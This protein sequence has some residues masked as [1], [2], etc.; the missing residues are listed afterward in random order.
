MEEE[1]TGSGGLRPSVEDPRLST[2]IPK[3]GPSAGPP[4]AG[5]PCE[6]GSL[7]LWSAQIQAQKDRE[8]CQP[9]LERQVENTSPRVPAAF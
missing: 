2:E 8:G 6:P 4:G 1:G 5:D 9:D 7:S 3:R